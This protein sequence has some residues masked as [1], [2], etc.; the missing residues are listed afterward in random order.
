[1]KQTRATVRYGWSCVAAEMWLLWQM[2]GPRRLDASERRRDS[3][4]PATGSS[5][6]LEWLGRDRRSRALRRERGDGR[7]RSQFAGVEWAACKLRGVLARVSV[8]PLL[9][10]VVES[11]PV[12]LVGS[13]RGH[14]GKARGPGRSP[15]MVRELA[16]R[17]GV[18]KSRQAATPVG[19]R[20]AKPVGDL[21]MLVCLDDE[22]LELGLV[23]CMCVPVSDSGK[24]HQSDRARFRRGL[25]R[26][27]GLNDDKLCVDGCA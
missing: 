11:S 18:L 7:R 26:K 17:T 23:P 27:M 12:S 22:D 21:M 15:L 4:Q 16:T 25:G 9:L 10:L 2:D 14:D 3:D 6:T 19:K 5:S 8:R 24:E 13:G 1:M 20:R